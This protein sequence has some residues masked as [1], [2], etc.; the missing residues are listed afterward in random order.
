MR[1]LLDQ[2]GVLQSVYQIEFLLLHARHF[3]LIELLLLAF[4]VQFLFDHVASSILLINKLLLPFRLSF[5]LLNFDHHFYVLRL[6]FFLFSQKLKSLFV[7][8]LLLFCFE[9]FCHSPWLRLHLIYLDVL[10]QFFFHRQ[11][12]LSLSCLLLKLLVLS[13]QFY[14]L[15]LHV[16][17][18]LH[19]NVGCPLPR[20]INLSNSL[21]N[22][23]VKLTYFSLF[24]FEQADSVA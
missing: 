16:T 1:L 12:G 15:I 13:L 3:H 19:D 9:G 24:L 6:F 4:A 18:S 5:S 22:C 11:V 17:S 21:Y 10:I 14:L 2:F 20:F 23:L 8:L 7:Q